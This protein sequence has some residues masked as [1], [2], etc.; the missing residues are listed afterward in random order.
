MLPPEQLAMNALRN[1]LR[2]TEYSRT[3]HLPSKQRLRGA[4]NQANDN[5][6]AYIDLRL[7]QVPQPRK[8]D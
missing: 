5:I 2:E 8:V 6:G 4:A 3:G 1:L 7:I